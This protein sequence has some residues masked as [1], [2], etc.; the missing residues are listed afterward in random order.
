VKYLGETPLNNEYTRKNEGQEC[1]TV[2]VGTSKRKMRR[3][4][5]GKH[6]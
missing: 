4:K 1:K 5:E 6:G 2:R 3:V